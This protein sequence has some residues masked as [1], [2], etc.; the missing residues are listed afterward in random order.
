MED[1]LYSKLYKM[2][3]AAAKLSAGFQTQAGSSREF[4]QKDYCSSVTVSRAHHPTLGHS[5]LSLC[6]PTEGTGNCGC[7]DVTPAVPY[8]IHGIDSTTTARI[9]FFCKSDYSITLR[10]YLLSSSHKLLHCAEQAARGCFKKLCFRKEG[11]LMEHQCQ[12]L[13]TVYQIVT[14]LEILT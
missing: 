2:A 11:Y 4:F 3:Q 12:L 9:S 13:S 14:V 8:S 7:T 5:T 10:Q 6:Q 1:S